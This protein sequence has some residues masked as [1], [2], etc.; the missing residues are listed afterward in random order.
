[1]HGR[2]AVK[3]TSNSEVVKPNI[4][5]D[6]SVNLPQGVDENKRCD[7]ESWVRSVSLSLSPHIY[8]YTL[9]ITY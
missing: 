8:I 7:T 2:A 9:I 6:I 3:H 4:A 5:F 1:M